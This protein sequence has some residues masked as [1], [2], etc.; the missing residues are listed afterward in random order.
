VIFRDGGEGERGNDIAGVN[1]LR[2]QSDLP[3]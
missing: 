2:G 1:I 3:L